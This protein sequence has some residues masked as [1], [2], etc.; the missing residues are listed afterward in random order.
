[1]TTAASASTPYPPLP[2]TYQ[3]LYLTF[4]ADR[5]A[6]GLSSLRLS[7]RDSAPLL[8]GLRQEE[9]IVAVEAASINP[10]D[11][12][13]AQGYMS[14]TRLPRILGRDFCGTVVRAGTNAEAQSLL[15]KQV[16]GTGGDLGFTLDGSF[17]QLLRL[18]SS[19]VVSLSPSSGLSASQAASVG[20]NFVTAAHGLARAGGVSKED[21]VLVT[22]ANGGVGAAVVQLAKRAGAT[23]IGVQRTSPKEGNAGASSAAAASAGS[24]ST[25]T[26]AGVA[27]ATLY[28]DA[29]GGFPGLSAAVR[30]HPLVQSRFPS[31]AGDGGD[32]H[33]TPGAT[34]AFDVVGGNDVIPHVLAALATRGRLSFIAMPLPASPLQVNGLNF[35]RQELSLM[36]VNSLLLSAQQSADILRTIQEGFQDGTLRPAQERFKEIKPDEIGPALSELGFGKAKGKLILM[37][38]KIA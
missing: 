28:L 24:A 33:H 23:V 34:L 27:D 6:S 9:V 7:E 2:S 19:A 25:T 18:P 22:G 31:T 29:I 38:P 4:F 10:S 14:S 30:S 11:V 35:Y 15:G 16:F 13:N 12:K 37:F 8:Q 5:S 17:S 20:V 1:M 21:I 32:A 36:G 26:A 3:A